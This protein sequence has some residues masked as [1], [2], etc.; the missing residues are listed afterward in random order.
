[1]GRRSEL[2]RP[3]GLAIEIGVAM[4]KRASSDMMFRQR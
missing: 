1:M 4:E 2:R 3:V